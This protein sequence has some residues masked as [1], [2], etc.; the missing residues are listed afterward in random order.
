MP[1]SE[2]T[3]ALAIGAGLISFLSP[4]VLPLVPAYLGQLSAVA[5]ARGVP[6]AAPSRF[7]ALRHAMAYVL[8]FGSVF[9]LLGLTATYALGG[10]AA[11]LPAMRQ[12]GGVILII[13]GLNLAG[14]LRIPFLERTYRPLDAGAAASVAGAT[15]SVALASP[16]GGT[17]F[18]DR[19]G[20]RLVT[21]GAAGWRPSDLGRSSQSGG[22]HASD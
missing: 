22:H 4:C 16:S 11:Y 10:F 12:V 6:G 15:G 5:A 20:G 8:G 21:S 9:T 2:L 7:L 13:L 3:I 19:L 17:S 14:I 18:G 1:T